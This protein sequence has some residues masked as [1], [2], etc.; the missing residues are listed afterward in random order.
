VFS[1]EK[2]MSANYPAVL[3]KAFQRAVDRAKGIFSGTVDDRLQGT[4]WIEAL[5]G[6]SVQP[7]VSLNQY[8]LEHRVNCICL[9][10]FDIQL[11]REKKG[12]ISRPHKN[13]SPRREKVVVDFWQSQNQGG[14]G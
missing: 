11:F 14:T 4:A 1:G 3:D 9:T 5:T 13:G 6:G 8:C 12:R 2:A 7:I 10:R